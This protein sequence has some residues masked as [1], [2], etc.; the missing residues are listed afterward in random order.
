MHVR[1]SIRTA[2]KEALEHIVPNTYKSRVYASNARPSLT[3]YIPSERSEYATMKPTPLAIRYATLM[4][5]VI[6]EG[7]A[8]TLDDA[9]DAYAVLVEKALDQNT[10]GGL[11]KNM[12]LSD[13]EL[14]IDGDGE[15]PQ[16]VLTMTYNVTYGVHTNDPETA[17]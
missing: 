1:S 15:T 11:V 2:A 3:V 12:Y 9:L 16:G 8:E 4:V 6:D 7:A 13:T 10:L 17:A 5:E 14:S